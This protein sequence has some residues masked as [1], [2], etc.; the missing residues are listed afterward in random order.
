MHWLK[1]THQSGSHDD[2]TSLCSAKRYWC[3]TCGRGDKKGWIGTL[4]YAAYILLLNTEKHW[5]LHCRNPNGHKAIVSFQE[6][7]FSSQ[8]V[9]R[10]PDWANWPQWL[11][12]SEPKAAFGFRN[13]GNQTSTHTSSHLIALYSHSSSVYCSTSGFSPLTSSR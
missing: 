8:R 6:P 13:N 3:Y 4:Q 7:C 10:W 12:W 1:F 9:R 2:R 11:C 5:K